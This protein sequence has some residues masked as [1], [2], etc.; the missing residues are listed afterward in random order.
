MRTLPR[1]AG[2]IPWITYALCLVE[3][4]ERASYYGAT[5]VFA[6]FL[7]YPLPKGINLH[8]I[9]RLNKNNRADVEIQAVMEL[10]PFQ[11]LTQ[12]I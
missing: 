5:Q 10:E 8:S 7:T 12:R 3:F 1:V 4:A 2:G 9:S 6:N 11:N